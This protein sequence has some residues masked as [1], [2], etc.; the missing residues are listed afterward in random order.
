MATFRE[1][2]ASARRMKGMTQVDLAV[3]LEGRYS[4]S[5]ISQIEN[6]RS[7]IALDGIDK[8][9]LALGVSTDYLLGV[10]DNPAPVPLH[11]PTDSVPIPRLPGMPATNQ[12]NAVSSKFESFPVQQAFLTEHQI[13]PRRAGIVAIKGQSMYPGLPH[14]AVVLV[15]LA[16][17]WLRHNLIYLIII[18][19]WAQDA[20]YEVRRLREDD[21]LG[22]QWDTDF[23]LDLQFGGISWLTGSWRTEMWKDE[24]RGNVISSRS[25]STIAPIPHGN[26]VTVLG[27]V[28]GVL[29]MFDDEGW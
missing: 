27:Q 6:G 10:T 18:N 24:I 16:R 14:G 1:R 4:Q 9:A 15:D 3:E 19:A 25:M 17:R 29:H 7:R 8:F 2:L 13:D 5:M 22:F 21:G 26:G 28:R 23:N 12:G 20:T 11:A